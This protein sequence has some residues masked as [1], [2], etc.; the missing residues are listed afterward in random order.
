MNKKMTLFG[1][2]SFLVSGIIVLDTFVAPAAL[3]A[4]SITLWFIVVILFMIPNGFINAELGGAYPDGL[5][6]W[7][8]KSMGEFHATIAGWFYWVNVAFWMPAVFIVFT[9]W[10]SMTFFP[11]GEGWTVLGQGQM[12]AIA[13]AATWILVAI[14]RKGIDT[15]I[16]MSK[17]A[18][19]IKISVLLLFGTLGIVHAFQNGFSEVFVGANWIPQLSDFG[20]L[21]LVTAIV[22]NLLGF[23]LVA[24]IGDDVKDPEKTIPKAIIIGAVIIGFLYIFA[25]FGVL[26]AATPADLADDAFILDGFII[27][28][29]ILTA[30]V[31][32]SAGPI[33]FKVIMG[34]ALFSLVMNMISWVIGANEIL[35]DVPFA[36]NFKVFNVRHPKYNTLS[37]SF[38]LMG[39]IS[40]VLI[41]VG[42]GLGESGDE[43]FWTI[44]AFSMV[45]FIF[46]YIY[47]TPAIL[48]LRKQDGDA[49]RHFMVPGG[50]LGLNIAA[51]LNFIFIALALVLLLVSNQ[52]YALYYPVVII[53][54]I[55]TTGIGVWFYKVGV[56]NS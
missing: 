32:G 46:P 50:K 48:K 9:Y 21:S 5:V 10:F 6:L 43:A 3:G 15:S 34:G 28:M 39:A 22:F 47:L 7:I 19:I 36:K 16:F 14:V 53:G 44:L 29:E 42:M 35:E 12:I 55:I 30:D 2:I 40:S 38:V 41:L 49:A 52:G 45:I 33:I 26:Q 11:D 8:K 51:I 20:S 54:T 13:I 37:K 24:A 17:I 31:F 27:S 56:K 1:L 18:T 4:S 23:E 25:T